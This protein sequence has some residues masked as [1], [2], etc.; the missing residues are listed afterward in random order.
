AGEPEVVLDEMRAE[1]AEARADL[2]RARV[3]LKRFE[4]DLARTDVRA[5]FPGRIAAREIAVGEF[6]APGRAV[7]RLVNTDRLEVS[8]QAPAQLLANVS[9]GDVVD[10]RQNEETRTGEVRALVPVGDEIS[11][12]MEVRIELN[13]APTDAA[14]W[15][16][17]S[18][19]QVRL[20]A[21]RA[22]T[23]VAAPRDALILRA[24]RISIFVVDDDGVAH[25]RDVR[26]GAADGDAIEIIG[27]L[28]PGERVVVRGGER[29]RDGETVRVLNDADKNAVS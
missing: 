19:V 20:P 27:D 1:A 7:V 29:L 25:R 24:G 3:A 17:G 21:A 28:A 18:A 9:I 23:V 13:E 12:T 22:A 16:I 5:P 6:A 8:A 11:R 10:V 4:T 15:H 2:Q 26:T 14:P